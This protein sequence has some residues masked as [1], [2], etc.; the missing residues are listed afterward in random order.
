MESTPLNIQR[1]QAFISDPKLLE[2][3]YVQTVV[4]YRIKVAKGHCQRTE[5]KR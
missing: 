2:M 1:P 5:S 4:N 3:F